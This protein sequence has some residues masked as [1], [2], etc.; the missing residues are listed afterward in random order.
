[1]DNSMNAI[2][3]SQQL[4]HEREDDCHANNNFDGL[5]LD[6]SDKTNA[7]IDEMC[8]RD[9][10]KFKAD[11]R[12]ARWFAFCLHNQDMHVQKVKR[13]GEKRLKKEMDFTWIIK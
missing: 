13:N 7:V 11:S 9:R 10:Y 8:S 6:R 3:T 5:G 12:C 1:M 2:F 4:R